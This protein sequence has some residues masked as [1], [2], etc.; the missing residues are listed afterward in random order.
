MGK[1]RR[2]WSAAVVA[3][4]LVAGCSGAGS[5]GA[6]EPAAGGGD[7]AVTLSYGMW[8][9]NQVPAMTQ[10]FD[11][12]QAANPG[13]SV[14]IELTPW[15]SY[16]TKLQTSA[17]SGQAPD[18]FWMNGPNFQLYAANQQLAPLTSVDTAPYPKAL[19]DLYTYKGSL[20]GVPKDLDTVGL[21]Y[22]KK[23]FDAADLGYPDDT[24]TWDTFKAAAK[25]LTNG[26]GQYG[27]A[28]QLTGQEG[29]Y[30]TIFQAGGTVLS[31]DG[32]K[33]AYDTP[34]AI[35]GLQFWRDLIAS[36]VSPNLKQMT[37]TA[38]YQMFEA[39]KVAMYWGGSWNAIEF[40]NNALTKANADVAVLPKGTER[41]TVIH[42]LANVVSAKSQHRAEAEKLA[43]FLGSQQAAEILAKTGTVIPA[44]EGTQQPWVQ[45]HPQFHLQNFLDMLDYAKPLPVSANTAAWNTLEQ[46][47]LVKAWT[48]E[49]PVAEAA[50]QL[51]QGMNQALSKEKG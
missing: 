29:Y 19:V 30:D 41:A 16:W 40:E 8:D 37:D 28:A 18:V 42:G 14:K 31:P 6:E 13:V 43:A 51:A 21:W 5:S 4:V 35:E 2:A 9:K 27:V 1:A 25:K 38:P 45:A 49:V 50:K 32:T 23:L 7:K 34:Q 24:W 12:Y 48:G 47:I 46:E 26:K 33:S 10:V 17:S 15:G 36:G 39:G 44:Y 20:Y 3:A 11:A 22:N